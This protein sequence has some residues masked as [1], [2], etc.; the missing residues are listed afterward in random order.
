MNLAL[1][2]IGQAGFRTFNSDG[3]ITDSLSFEPL[4]L[5]KAEWVLFHL[6]IALLVITSPVSFWFCIK[7]VRPYDHGLHC[8]FGRV[9]KVLGPGLTL[10]NPL[11][12]YIVIFEPKTFR[13]QT[14]KIIMS[15]EGQFYLIGET[16]VEYR[17]VKP[18]LALSVLPESDDYVRKMALVETEKLLRSKDALTIVQK[19]NALEETVKM[20]IQ[21]ALDPTG[22]EV[23]RVYLHIV[24]AIHP[25]AM[26][27]NGPNMM[28]H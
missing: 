7:T 11:T 22:Y 13:V 28:Y 25:D 21:M 9:V 5:T 17:M 8:R 10:Y 15:Y 27:S 24:A 20:S 16:F 6:S 26:E 12:D 18:A 19:R 3:P 4:K 2:P 23:T 1:Q 14:D